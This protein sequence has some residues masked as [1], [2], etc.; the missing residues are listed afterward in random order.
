[1]ESIRAAGRTPSLSAA[2]TEPGHRPQAQAA[3]VFSVEG[4]LGLVCEGEEVG[5]ESVFAVLD[6][7]FLGRLS[8]A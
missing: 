7:C 8:V 4:G 3:D 1:M 6:E 5:D 2:A